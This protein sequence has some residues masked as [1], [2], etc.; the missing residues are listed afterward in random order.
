VH[1][2]PYRGTGPAFV[3]TAESGKNVALSS[4][5]SINWN[6]PSLQLHA[7][8]GMVHSR[9]I[10]SG[11]GNSCQFINSQSIQLATMLTNKQ[12]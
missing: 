1:Y 8:V 2:E 7:S 5:R 12:L 9:I 11:S 6:G 4:D 10:T 3:T